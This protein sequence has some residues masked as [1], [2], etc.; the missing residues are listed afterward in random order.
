M[1]EWGADEHLL[2]V[3]HTAARRDDDETYL[4]TLLD[5][6]LVLPT[7]PSDEGW[8]M[9]ETDDGP[10]VF[11]FSSVE[12]MRASLA[13]HVVTGV[14]WP[15]LDLLH[16]WPDP[17]W[18]LL[19]DGSHGSQVLILPDAIAQLATRAVDAYPLDTA[20]RGA[21]GHPRS[22][23]N[24][25]IAADVV[26]PL[27]PKG[28]P[29]HDLAKPDFAWWRT[30]DSAADPAVVLFSSPVRLQVS[31]GDVPWLV[32][33]FVEVVRHFPDGCAAQVD[34]DHQ[35]GMRLPGEAMA[36]MAAVLDTVLD[37]HPM[38]QAG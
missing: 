16:T 37:V 22:Y 26:V 33:P 15:V 3:L 5:I 19:V 36:G 9:T 27:R 4:A 35:I 25:L 2:T 28:S 1:N 7:S 11:A 13:D 21:A 12:L 18:S 20:L 10:I 30:G 31:L 29:T 14:V 34:P 38:R 6:G 23:L 8:P 17:A 32:A 24:T